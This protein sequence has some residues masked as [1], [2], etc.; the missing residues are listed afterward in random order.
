MSVPHLCPGSWWRPHYWH[1][2][3]PTGTAAASALS[4]CGSGQP[5]SSGQPQ[6]HPH[7]LPSH[8]QR[9]APQDL[10]TVHTKHIPTSVSTGQKR[11]KLKI[12]Q[13]PHLQGA[14]QGF[15][16]G[17]Q[18]PRGALRGAVRDRK[19]APLPPQAGPY[20]HQAEG[21]ARHGRG[22]PHAPAR[23][24]RAG[25]RTRRAGCRPPPR[26]C[27]RS[28]CRWWGCRACRPPAAA[29]C[30]GAAWPSLPRSA[31]WAAASAPPPAPP[32]PWART[33]TGTETDRQA[34]THRH[35]PRRRRAPRWRQ[36]RPARGPTRRRLTAEPRHRPSPRRAAG[37]GRCSREWKIN[38]APG[39]KAGWVADLGRD[40]PPG[41]VVAW[42]DSLGS[43]RWV[44]LLFLSLETQ[45]IWVSTLIPGLKAWF[46]LMIVEL[47]GEVAPGVG[48]LPLK[49]D[50]ASWLQSCFFF[51]SSQGKCAPEGTA[52]I[53]PFPQW[54]VQ[55]LKFSWCDRASWNRNSSYR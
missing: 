22:S 16:C 39:S 6:R 18:H 8:F 27:A 45:F 10:K 36:R 26:T 51:F 40:G 42:R 24:R 28:C 11:Q 12:R 9:A 2:F 48:W 47:G 32:R 21:K 30:R 44:K 53:W 31:P 19:A 4:R 37:A 23:G 54:P 17:S 15:T 49:S 3:P 34:H 55:L 43:R 25:P 20:H 29:R 33:G 35:R 38:K 50:G 1:H 7:P 5:P 14:T 13:G 46:V 41:N 52:A